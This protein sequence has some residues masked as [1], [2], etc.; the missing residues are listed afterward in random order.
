M[1]VP[2]AEQPYRAR[3]KNL[4]LLFGDDSP[5]SRYLLPLEQIVVPPRQ[6]RRHFDPRKMEQLIASVKAHGILEN[7][8]VRPSASHPDMYELV[9][10]ERRFS[11]ATAVGLREVPVTIRELDDQQA[12]QLALVENLQREDL[13]PVEETEGILQLLGIRLGL[14]DAEVVSL[15]Y[16]LQNESRGKVTDNVVGKTEWSAIEE[17]FSS[18]GRLSWG[19]FIAHRLPLLNLPPDVLDALRQNQLAY[20]KARA[21]ARIADPTQRATLLQ[22]TLQDN[23]SLKVIRQLVSAHLPPAPVSTSVSRQLQLL[24]GRIVAERVWQNPKKRK[25]LEKLMAQL[26]TL[27]ADSGPAGNG[28]I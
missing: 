3:V 14:S 6:V 27:L 16:R 5:A 25:K 26:E 18:V 13:N 15:L 21:I 9:A 11:A 23:L 7:L 1:T 20:T 2:K 22:A 19:S 4:G 10:G 8:V 28:T 24:T 12:V 17:T